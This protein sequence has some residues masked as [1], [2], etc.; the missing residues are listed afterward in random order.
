MDREYDIFE[1]LPNGSS[2]WRK[3]ISGHEEAIRAFKEFAKQTPNEV[4]LMYLPT[5]TLIA[6][7]NTRDGQ[8]PLRLREDS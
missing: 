6:A 2:I 7:V 3:V 1:I 5:T 4:R 8:R